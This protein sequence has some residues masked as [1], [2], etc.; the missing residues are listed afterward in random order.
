M[1]VGAGEAA[2]Q[3]ADTDT[4]SNTG[5]TLG[6]RMQC[7]IVKNGDGEVG[8]MRITTA[9]ILHRCNCGGGGQGY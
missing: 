7:N 1:A 3:G 5:A 6:M 8:A 2:A 4:D 9:I